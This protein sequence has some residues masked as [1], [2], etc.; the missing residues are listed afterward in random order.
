MIKQ[1]VLMNK[2]TKQYMVVLPKKYLPLMKK[3]TPKFLKFKQ[4]DIEWE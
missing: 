1:K 2:R 4:R 3:K